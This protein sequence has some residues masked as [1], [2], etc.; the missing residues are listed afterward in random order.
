MA[1]LYQRY[2]CLRGKG[3]RLHGL[4]HGYLGIDNNTLWSIISTNV[5]ELLPKLRALSQA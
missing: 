3:H 4:I 5:P 2:D 1:F